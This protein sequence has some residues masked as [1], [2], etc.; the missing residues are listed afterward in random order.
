LAGY[1]LN[2]MKGPSRNEIGRQTQKADAAQHVKEQAHQTR[3]ALEEKLK[4]VNAALTSSAPLAS[5]VRITEDIHKTDGSIMKM[6]WVTQCVRRCG[7]Q[8][9]DRHLVRPQ[10]GSS[11]ILHSA[12]CSS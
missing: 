6:V 2:R 5:A 9:R 11:A 3:E 12:G 8:T 4:N 7:S 10:I 1:R